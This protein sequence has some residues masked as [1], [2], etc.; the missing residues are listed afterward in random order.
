[1]ELTRDVTTVVW[2]PVTGCDKVSAGC[3][4]CYALNLSR[5]LKAYGQ[6]KY[7]TDGDPVTSG[8]GFG[9][10]LHP[11]ALAQPARWRRP[12][13]V[14]VESMGDLF[15][16]KVPLA[17][18]RDVFAVMRD[19]PRHTYWLLTKRPSRARK[20][21]D[22][23]DWPDNLW[24]GAS[25]EDARVAHRIDDLRGVPARLR[26]LFCEPLLGPLERL[27]LDGIGW[28][29]VAGEAGR[30]A[31][32]MQP[33]WATGGRDQAGA[34]GIPFYFKQWGGPRSAARGRELEGR[35]WDE[36]PDLRRPGAADAAP[37]A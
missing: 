26:M 19:T 1:M 20:L 3:D 15:H 17:F 6:P 4:H 25:V 33:V 2:N 11:D 9:V 10:A 28:V 24:F 27:N 16:A 36:V 32:P 30:T 37:A 23:L 31:R 14:F 12:R 34:A 35:I 13:I 18:V 22:R 5:R 21:A 29:T 7:Q 8:P